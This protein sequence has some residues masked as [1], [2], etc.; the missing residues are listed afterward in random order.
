[1]TV[2]LNHTII[3]AKDKKESARFL[4]EILGS[5]SPSPSAPSRPCRSTA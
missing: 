3:P 5:P 4:S 2:Q 1:M